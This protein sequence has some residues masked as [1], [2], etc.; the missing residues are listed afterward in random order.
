[1][2]VSKRLFYFAK[3]IFTLL[4]INSTSS[5]IVYDLE[6]NCDKSYNCDT[7]QNVTQGNSELDVTD[8]VCAIPE[9][10]GASH[11][12]A[13]PHQN[14]N[15]TIMKPHRSASEVEDDDCVR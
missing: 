3:L 6:D 1:M 15:D 8:I 4:I 5:P 14:H 2:E 12:C 10:D 11:E 9:S 7:D 13:W